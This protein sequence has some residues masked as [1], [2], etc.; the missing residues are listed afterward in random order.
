MMLD[1]STK[2]SS[3]EPDKPGEI[4]SFSHSIGLSHEALLG[5][6]I[7]LE[8][9]PRIPIQSH[10]EKLVTEVKA[11]A[12]MAVILT[13][14]RSNIDLNIS[15]LLAEKYY[16]APSN[17]L[18]RNACD[19]VVP[20]NDTSSL[21]GFIMSKASN[22]ATTYILLDNLTDLILNSG[23]DSTYSTVMHMADIL[24]ERMAT[25]VLL[26]NSKAHGSKIL[27]AFETVANLIIVLEDKKLRL[28]KS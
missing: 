20:L 22:E 28:I 25:L 23:L 6:I 21:L 13:R 16:L 11:N 27:A 15:S 1:C 19:K 14:K 12:E 3:Y 5:K 9:D 7:I 10:I 24:T 18:Y 17:P 2:P 26:L 4:D 8:F